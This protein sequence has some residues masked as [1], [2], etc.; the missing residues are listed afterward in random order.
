MLVKIG[1]IVNSHGVMGEVRIMSNSDFSD[2]R[3]K[4]GEKFAIRTKNNDHEVRIEKIYRH[5]NFYVCKLE[6]YNNIND[7]LKYKGLD[8]YAKQ[9][10][11][12]MLKEGEY[13]NSDLVGLNIIDQ[14]NNDLGKS[15]EI[16]DNPAHNL[17]RIK[18]PNNKT[19]L[20]PF[21]D[22]YITDVNLASKTILINRIGGLI[23]ED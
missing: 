13:L 21:N 10:T 6:G 11:N 4:K 14:Y 20:I 2:I 23:D 16:I 22:V 15:I 8:I 5:K 12:D 3:F 17:V 7:I 19:Y 1:K 18:H 9:I